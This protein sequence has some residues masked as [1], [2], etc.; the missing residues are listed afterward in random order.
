M[1]CKANRMFLQSNK[2]SNTQHDEDH[3]SSS[4]VALFVA[5]QKKWLHMALN[6]HPNKRKKYGA[7]LCFFFLSCL[8]ITVVSKLHQCLAGFDT[9][10]PL[11]S[12]CNVRFTLC[13]CFL[14]MCARP[15]TGEDQILTKS[16]GGSQP[17][18]LGRRVYFSSAS[19]HVATIIGA[20]QCPRALLDNLCSFH[21]QTAKTATRDCK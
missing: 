12:L 1:Q 3:Q 4:S 15:T 11:C 14:H 17:S 13:C 7:D 9:R 16:L 2:S 21:E 20:N 18:G 5:K 19:R 10:P 8:S 6:G